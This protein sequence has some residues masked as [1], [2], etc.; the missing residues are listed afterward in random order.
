MSIA[1]VTGGNHG[2]GY[3]TARALGGTGGSVILTG[4]D[5]TRTAEAAD[6]LRQ[7]GLDVQALALA[8]RRRRASM[9]PSTTCRSTTA[10]STCW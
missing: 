1:L 7:E 9:R 2:L 8:S 4:R 3:A 6:A 10:V 5:K